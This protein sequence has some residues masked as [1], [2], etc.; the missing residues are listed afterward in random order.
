MDKKWIPHGRDGTSEIPL[1]G[2][3]VSYPYTYN[4]PIFHHSSINLPDPTLDGYLQ[5][6]RDV[7]DN[8]DA[9]YCRLAATNRP[10]ENRILDS[11]PDIELPQFPRSVYLA[12]V[13]LGLFAFLAVVA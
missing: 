12:I 2:Q 1:R 7:L 11:L 6:D 13:P 3:I 8:H 5:R 4:S 9:A 10:H